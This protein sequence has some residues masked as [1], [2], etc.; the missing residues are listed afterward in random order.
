MNNED[1]ISV[2]DIK[3]IIADEIN[4]I[5][6]TKTDGDENLITVDVKKLHYKTE[7]R[8]IMSR[9]MEFIAKREEQNHD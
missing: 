9:I 5:Q 1:M 7:C 4:D 2:A 3:K 6:A 8:V